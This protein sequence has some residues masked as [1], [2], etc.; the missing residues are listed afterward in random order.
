MYLVFKVQEFFSILKF[1]YM[2]FLLWVVNGLFALMYW[3]PLWINFWASFEKIWKCPRWELNSRCCYLHKYFNLHVCP[4]SV[5]RPSCPVPTSEFYHENSFRPLFNVILCRP[6]GGA[7]QYPRSGYFLVNNIPNFQEIICWDN[8]FSNAVVCPRCSVA[9]LFRIL[10]F[11]IH[12]K[13][14]LL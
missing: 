12:Y 10:L 7:R 6:P 8:I 9:M 1:V 3:M 11:W 4:S 13:V 2:A 14:N 5:R